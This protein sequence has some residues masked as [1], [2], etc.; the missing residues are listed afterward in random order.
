[1]RTLGSYLLLVS[2]CTTPS[3]SVPLE[4]DFELAPGQTVTIAGTGHTVTF[5]SVAEDS[6]CPTGVTCVWAGNARVSLRLGVA[7]RDTTVA[8]NTGIEPRTTRIGDVTLELKAVT[9]FPQAGT[10]T[11]AESY[12]VTLRAGGA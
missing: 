9:P 4:G 1:M 3:S 7:G 8:L 5:E 11:P 6:R 10:S 12:R 2:A